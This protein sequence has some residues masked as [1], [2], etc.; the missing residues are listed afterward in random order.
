MKHQQLSF[1]LVITDPA[2]HRRRLLTKPRRCL[3]CDRTFAS[4]GP[5]NRICTAC[6]GREAW[7]GPADFAVVSTASTAGF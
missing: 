1:G 2:E 5:G 3:S 6:K 4:C 7:S